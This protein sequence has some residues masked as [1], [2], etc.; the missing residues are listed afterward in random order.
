MHPLMLPVL[1]TEIRTSATFTDLTDAKAMLS[2]VEEETDMNDF[3]TDAES[4]S[5]SIDDPLALDLSSLVKR[6]STCSVRVRSYERNSEI[7]LEHL[8]II[9]NDIDGLASGVSPLWADVYG[10]FESSSGELKRHIGYLVNC[11]KILLLLIQEV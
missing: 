9:R 1:I 4:A 2:D 7:A 11:Q 5:I 3:I 8:R 6:L 10:H